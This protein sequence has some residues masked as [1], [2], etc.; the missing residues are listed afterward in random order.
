MLLSR[1]KHF[2]IVYDPKG[3]GFYI[4]A[5]TGRTYLNGNHLTGGHELVEGDHITAGES[6]YIFVPFC[7]EGRTWT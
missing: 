6:E 7:K 1:E 5:E 3:S 4:I 2:S